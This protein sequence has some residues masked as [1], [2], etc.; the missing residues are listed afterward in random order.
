[1]ELVVSAPFGC[2]N[3]N[4]RHESDNVKE[5][6]G[7][8]EK[9]IPVPEMSEDKYVAWEYEEIGRQV[10]PFNKCFQ[11]LFQDEKELPR[12][13]VD[14][15][16]VRDAGG[17]HHVFYF[18]ISVQSNAARAQFEQAVKDYEGGKPIDPKR[19]MWIEKAMAAQKKNSRIVR[20]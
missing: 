11:Q 12:K 4:V 13:A 3:K 16:V 14:R 7:S 18:D 20:L 2:P 5:L 8:L 10:V 15:I 17:R 1:M 9:P 19:K 6:H